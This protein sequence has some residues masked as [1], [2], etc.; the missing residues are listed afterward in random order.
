M[1][2]GFARFAGKQGKFECKLIY[3]LSQRLQYIHLLDE[4]YELVKY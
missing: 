1:Y 4:Y 2:S 3:K